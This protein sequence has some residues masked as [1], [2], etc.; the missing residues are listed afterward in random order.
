MPS[1]SVS[2]MNKTGKYR[3]NNPLTDNN[4]DSEINKRCDKYTTQGSGKIWLNLRV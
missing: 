2:W 1:Y 4:I 3:I